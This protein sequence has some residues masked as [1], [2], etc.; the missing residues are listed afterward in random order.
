MEEQGA[1][2]PP[3]LLGTEPQAYSEA[4]AAIR[5][6]PRL[7]QLAGLPQKLGQDFRP[8]GAVLLS[9][10]LS[11]AIDCVLA[12]GFN[13]GQPTSGSRWALNTL[14]QCSMC[15]DT[16]S[17]Q[18]PRE[19]LYALGVTESDI[20]AA[21]VSEL[22]R[23]LGS[24]ATQKLL[25][26]ALDAWGLDAPDI[27][28]RMLEPLCADPPGPLVSRLVAEGRAAKVYRHL[29]PEAKKKLWTGSLHIWCMEL[30][31]LVEL[32]IAATEQQLQSA[33]DPVLQAAA[34]APQLLW[35]A[36]EHLIG[37]ALLSGGRAVLRMGR[38]LVSGLLARQRSCMRPLQTPLF[39]PVDLRP[40]ATLLVRPP[41]SDALPLVLTAIEETGRCVSIAIHQYLILDCRAGHVLLQFCEPWT[42][43]V[44]S[45]VFAGRGA[46]S[47]LQLV[48]WLAWPGHQP[49]WRAAWAETAAQHTK[50]FNE[51]GLVVAEQ[52]EEFRSR[53]VAL[54]AELGVAACPAA[55]AALLQGAIGKLWREHPGAALVMSTSK[56][57]PNE[58]R[59]LV[60][61]SVC[62][63]VTGCR[64]TARAGC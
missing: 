24:G 51:E 57:N 3:P 4:A 42:S 10:S 30:N 39:F 63:A 1:P 7:E 5:A 23:A 20:S 16:P 50:R 14:R 45:S 26:K 41:T 34:R 13:Q 9:E 19:L 35:V 61:L 43:F 38:V 33:V 28:A 12:L 11:P 55:L 40:L 59:A 36:I 27:V 29:S 15:S 56:V 2:D 18:Q 60:M 46:V 54:A 44:Y 48:G 32:S 53:F 22:S 17:N 21:Y 52:P 58:I 47:A 25:Q 6:N 37:V 62:V 49:A 31:G 8:G 64:R